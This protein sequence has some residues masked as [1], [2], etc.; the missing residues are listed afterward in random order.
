MRFEY[1]VHAADAAVVKA[2][3]GRARRGTVKNERISIHAE[4][5]VWQAMVVCIDSL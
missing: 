1:F 4:C 5:V 3:G 2:I